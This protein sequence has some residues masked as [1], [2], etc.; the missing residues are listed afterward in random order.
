MGIRLPTHLPTPGGLGVLFDGVSFETLHRLVIVGRWYNDEEQNWTFS[1]LQ[2]PGDETKDSSLTRYLPKIAES[3]EVTD[4]YVP[5]PVEFNGIVCKWQNLHK[6]I[7]LGPLHIHRGVKAEGCLIAPGKA[8]AIS[9]A[10]CA[11]LIGW[12]PE[13]KTAG[14]PA[15]L[16]VAH[17][18]LKSVLA[19]VCGNLIAELGYRKDESPTDSKFFIECSINPRTYFHEWN[20]ENGAANRALCEDVEKYF[21]KQCLP[22]WEI[23]AERVRGRINLAEM[24]GADLRRHGA[25][26]KNISIGASPDNWRGDGEEVFYTTRGPNPE[27]NKKRN[28][29]IVQNLASL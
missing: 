13:D 29:I 14:M 1:N 20:N 21:G 2:N 9:A 28:L 7:C 4:F 6:N 3:L 23:G 22:G 24:I 11:I 18:G 8:F 5:S 12:R 15:R 16:V 26:E 25:P 17:A 19:G 10:G 27:R